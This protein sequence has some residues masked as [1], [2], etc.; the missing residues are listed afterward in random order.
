[1]KRCPESKNHSCLSLASSVLLLLSLPTPEYG[2]AVVTY[3]LSRFG[4]YKGQ[5]VCITGTRI[6]SAHT[7]EA[8]RS[9]TV[10]SRKVDFYVDTTIRFEPDYFRPFPSVDGVRVDLDNRRK[11]TDLPGTPYTALTINT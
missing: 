7:S 6:E 11:D 1:M 3:S 9:H 5:S 2:E 8:A 10:S 4:P